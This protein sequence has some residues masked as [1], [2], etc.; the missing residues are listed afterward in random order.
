[1]YLSGGGNEQQSFP[2][3]KFFF[4]A[5]PV[6]GRFLY[7]PI[8]LRGHKRILSIIVHEIIHLSIEPLIKKYHGHVADLSDKNEGD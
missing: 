3:D 8:A 1:M 2:L 5:L 6:G 4:N 7:V